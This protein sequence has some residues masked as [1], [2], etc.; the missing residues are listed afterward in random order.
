MHLHSHVFRALA[1]SPVPPH[2]RNSAVAAVQAATQ[3]FE[4]LLTDV[5][6][7]DGL[8][9]MP[10]Y[11]H[12][13]IAFA[14][15][16]LLQVTAKYNGSFVSPSTVHDLIGRLVEQLRSMPTGKW[17]LVRLLVEGLEKMTKASLKA[18]H[19][20]PAPGYQAAAAQ[21][22]NGQM[23]NGPGM[24]NNMEYVQRPGDFG[25]SQGDSFT[26][27]DFG[28]SSSFLPFEDVNSL[29]RSTDLGYL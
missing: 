8:V 22:S 20:R 17:H 15:G 29:F 7:R 11:T 16:F 24:T 4:L 5:S 18:Q 23:Q 21:M 10:H 9:G 3:V 6:L 28:L 19:S 27:P 25:V 2:F 26:M 14:C 1:D 13:M 12:T